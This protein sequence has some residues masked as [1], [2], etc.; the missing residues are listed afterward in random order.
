M[1]RSTS[2]VLVGLDGGSA[3]GDESLQDGA[4]SKVTL[5]LKRWLFF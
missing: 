2:N 5:W 1:T 3:G 4:P